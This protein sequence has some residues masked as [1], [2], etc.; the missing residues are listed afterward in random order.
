M[1]KQSDIHRTHQS[2]VG[3]DKVGG[4]STRPA[5]TKKRIVG[6]TRPFQSDSSGTGIGGSRRKRKIDESSGF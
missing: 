6:P 5:L 1:P 2:T 3:H 4:V